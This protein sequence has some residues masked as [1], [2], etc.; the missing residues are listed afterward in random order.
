MKFKFWGVRGS[1]PTPGAQTNKY[2]GNT[3][4]IEIRTA[5]DDLIIFDA[6][7]GIHQLMQTLLPQMPIDAHILITHTHWDHIHGLPF[8]MPIY[9]PGNKLTIYG[10]QDLKTGEGIERALKVQMQH[11]FFPIAES[12][13]KAEVSYKTVKVGEKFFIADATITP[14]LLNH[15]VINFGYRID[16]DG[17][18]LFFTGD[19]EQQVNIYTPEDREYL[20]FEQMIEAYVDSLVSI[21]R[22][23]DVL[24]IDSSFTDQEYQHKKNWGHG[25]YTAAIK[26]AEK[27]GAKKLFFTHHEPTRSDAA[28]DAIYEELLKNNQELVCELFVAQEGLEVKL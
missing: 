9:I 2:G 21:I 6:G 3:T 17:K 1:I 5:N 10:G 18:S 27:V 8:C 4:C 25:T 12:E 16:C 24:I 7:T 11:S 14:V 28:L 15:P 22:D 19:Y 23:V 13:L 20:E 26:L